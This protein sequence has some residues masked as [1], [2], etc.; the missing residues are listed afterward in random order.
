M[1][2]TPFSLLDTKTQTHMYTLIQTDNW[3]K[4]VIYEEK[5]NELL[6]LQKVCEIV[7]VFCVFACKCVCVFCVFA[8]EC[9]CVC[10]YRLCYLKKEKDIL[11]RINEN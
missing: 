2:H 10:V 4:A 3:F 11:H 1:I 8:C 9:V 5:I 7:C 6:G